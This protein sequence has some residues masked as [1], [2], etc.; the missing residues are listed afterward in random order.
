MRSIKNPFVYGDTVSGEAFWDRENE[1][2]E[3]LGD[4]RSRQHV[5][6]LSRRRF[7]KTSLVWK[8]LEEA[9]KEGFIPVYVDLYPISTVA[10]FIEA[11]AR[12]IAGAL[13]KYEKA[14]KLMRGL[15]SRLYLS[16][17]IDQVGNPQW[18]VGFD[19]NME[20]ESFDEVV[21]SL[22]SYL[23]KK[24]KYGVVVFD[25]FQQIVEIDGEK[26]ERRMRSAIQ[27]HRRITYFFVGSKRHLMND[28]FTDPNRPFY[29]S[30]K[31]FPLGKIA[32]HDLKETIKK[33]FHEAKVD[34]DRQAL[35]KI[36]EVT[37]GHPYYAQYLCH[38]LYN[39]I[40]KSRIMAEDVPQAL[41]LLLR[42]ESTAYM[43]TWDLL[44]QRQRQALIILSETAPDEN[45]YR[46]EM[47]RRFNISQP[48]VV[49]RALKS[50]INKN[51]ID[52]EDGR[53]EITDLFFKRWIRTYITQSR[54]IGP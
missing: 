2:K 4:I 23:Q 1:T 49:I 54:P 35:E 11:Y 28:L 30:G 5:I 8:V 3:L 13:S 41:D 46:T 25:E 20:V 24:K 34:I 19:K 44:T 12:A 7:G 9:S 42:R 22:D 27:T 21:S 15:F 6:L 10:D 32:S 33:R 14:V 51:L 43:N 36:A 48:A 39:M 18:N 53:Y 37:E 47:L 26:M 45:P 29:R 50:L 52:R 31:T 16:M 38:I 17:G 40:E